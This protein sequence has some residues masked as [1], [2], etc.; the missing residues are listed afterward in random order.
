MED[1]GGRLEILIPFATL[2]PVRELLL[3]MFM[4]EKFGQD[5]VWEKHLGKE[6]R[7]THVAIEAV[8]DE[9][10]ITLRDV[11]H[12]KV[13]STILLDCMPDD[14][15]ILKCGGVVV[16]RGKLGR[17]GE[18]MAIAVSDSVADRQEQL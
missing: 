3:Q 4:G 2:E 15:V 6:L 14:D 12:F 5:T 11:M 1:R 13:G 18:H 10:E 16:S 9:K 8:L 7:H 17:V